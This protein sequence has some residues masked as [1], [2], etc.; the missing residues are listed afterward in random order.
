MRPPGRG[1]TARE[2]RAVGARRTAAALFPLWLVAIVI[3]GFASLSIAVMSIF[4]GYVAGESNWSKGQKDAVHALE[5][6]ASTGAEADY[7]EFQARIAVP[8]ADRTAKLEMNKADPDHE[9]ITNAFLN[10]K[11]EPQDIDGM[12]WLY[13]NFKTTPWFRHAANYWDIGD[14][15]LLRLRDIG[16][17]LHALA[18]SGKGNDLEAFQLVSEV[19]NIDDHLAPVEDGFSRSLDEVA[20]QTRDALVLTLTTSAL[21]LLGVFTMFI[22]RS[23]SRGE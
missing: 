10:G 1:S 8:L 23:F 18:T 9:V 3:T 6:F 13:R 20:H 14:V 21:L 12:I 17:R 4:L 11:I 19:Q 2:T 16:S 5:R 15:Y 7:Q 22:W